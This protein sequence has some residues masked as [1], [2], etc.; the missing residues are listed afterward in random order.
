MRRGPY[1]PYVQIDAP[2]ET[3]EEAAAYDEKVAAYEERYAK[4][5]EKAKEKGKDI[6]VKKLPKRPVKKPKRQGLP[7]EMT[8]DDV[9]LKNALALLA[10]PRD[11]GE[12]P[13]TGKM[14]KA[15]IGRFGPFVMHDGKFASIPKDEDVM[16]IG[17]N[18]AVDLIA[19]KMERDAAKEAAKAA[20]EASKKAPAKK[21]TK[22]SAKKSAK[23]KATKKKAASKKSAKN[24][25]LALFKGVRGSPLAPD[26]V[27]HQS[28]RHT[29]IERSFR[30]KFIPIFTC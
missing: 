24:K 21:A 5:V 15:G 4:R 22:K 30:N 11:V 12:H 10:L 26:D 9:T 18:R 23:K 29:D 27:S 6:P 28:C 8:V 7:K 20:K 19:K 14:I 3:A 1:G 25:T 17:M 16:T 13:E 2:P